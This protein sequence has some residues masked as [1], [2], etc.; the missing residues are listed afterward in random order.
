MFNFIFQHGLSD[1]QIKAQLRELEDNAEFQ[2]LLEMGRNEERRW[3]KGR[4]HYLN[5]RIMDE[6]LR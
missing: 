5:G 2:N 4:E 3:L 1:D 6:Y